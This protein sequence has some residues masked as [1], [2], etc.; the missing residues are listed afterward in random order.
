MVMKILNLFNLRTFL[1]LLISQLSAFLVIHYQIKYQFDFLLFGLAIG[2]PLAFSIQAAFRRRDR[3]L[4]Y[5]SMFKGGTLAIHYSFAVSED[6]LPEKKA[7]I[8]RILKS[9]G[10]Q[11]ILQLKHRIINYSPMQEAIDKILEFIEK[12]REAI[13]N[14]NVLRII[15][16]IRDVTESSTYLVSLIRHRTMIGLRVYSLAFILIFPIIQAP[17][18]YYKLGDLIPVWAFYFLLAL[19]SLLLITLSNFQ[20][21]IEYPFDSK[22]I[23]NIYLEDFKLDIPE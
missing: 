8:R 1:V 14:R 15:R 6:L 9:M 18:L 16:Y 2:F 17:I 20:K 11:L 7:E 5:F 19:G 23:D 12:N 3:A 4:E 13:S 22:G 21:M 10:D